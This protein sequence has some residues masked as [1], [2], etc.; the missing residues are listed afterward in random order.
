MSEP[1]PIGQILKRARCPTP[2][3]MSPSQASK[4]EQDRLI[5]D[6]AMLFEDLWAATGIDRRHIEDMRDFAK[7]L[8]HDPWAKATWKIDEIVR[9]AGTAVVL[10]DRGNGKTQ[11]AVA[12]GHRACWRGESVMY[13]RCREIGMAVRLS[14]RSDE[15]SEREAIQ[16]FVEPHLLIVDE[17]QERFN[18]EHELRTLTL[19]L[20]K[21]YGAMVPT[22]L[23]ANCTAETFRALMGP[24]IVDRIRETG[25][26]VM[27]DWPSFRG[28]PLKGAVDAK[29]ESH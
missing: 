27:F 1:E 2:E 23:I 25:Q 3:P 11:A 16:R 9:A 15:I 4:V 12:A 24:S 21:R 14:Y 19:I 22:I 8:Q 5:R 28:Q 6:R 20:D 7:L 17:C 18:T 26:V 13:L 29:A 10:G